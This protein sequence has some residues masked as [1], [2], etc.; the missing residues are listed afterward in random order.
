MSVCKGCFIIKDCDTYIMD[1]PYIDICPCTK[2]LVKMICQVNICE[3]YTVFIRS[4][5][6]NK[7]FIEDMKL[8]NRPM[9]V[10]EKNN[11]LRESS[12]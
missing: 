8:N 12:K 3:E 6:N 1:S 7:Q 11:I 2:C 4:I 9:K 10:S 5:Y